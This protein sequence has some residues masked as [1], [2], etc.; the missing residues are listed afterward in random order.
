MT[1]SVISTDNS[2][3][4]WADIEMIKTLSSDTLKTERTDNN[5]N[6]SGTIISIERSKKTMD[7]NRHYLKFL[8]VLSF[9]GGTF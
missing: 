6:F 4:P 3:F 9:I 8:D 1:E 5:V 7:Y 2:L